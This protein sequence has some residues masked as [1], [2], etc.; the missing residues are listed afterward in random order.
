MASCILKLILYT[1]HGL[2]SEQIKLKKIRKP[3]QN[4]KNQAKPIE[5]VFSLKKP[6]Q[7]RLV[8]PG[9]GFIQKKSI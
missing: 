8:W 1:R 4:R 6:N 3:S 2:F 7:N 9:F 5:P